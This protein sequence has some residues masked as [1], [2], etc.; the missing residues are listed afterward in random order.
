M[1][2]VRE[3]RGERVE[4][5]R[6][7]PEA[8]KEDERVAATAPVENLERYPWANWYK[9]ANRRSRNTGQSSLGPACARANRR[10]RSQNLECAY[11]TFH[12]PVLRP[13]A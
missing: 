10:E 2:M 1:K 5:V 3:L 11:Q 8:G 7:V 4:H 13:N 12:H 9:A 6:R